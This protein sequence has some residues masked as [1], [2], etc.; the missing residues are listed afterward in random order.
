MPRRIPLLF[1]F[2]AVV[3]T[4]SASAQTNLDSFSLGKTQIRIPTPDGFAPV[5]SQ[6]PRVFGRF[7]ATESADN[8]V[9]EVHVE[10]RLL[11]DLIRN[12]DV[13]LIFY[14]KVSA[15]REAVVLD[16][17][18]FSTL[19]KQ[20]ESQIGGFFDPR[21]PQLAAATQSIRKG[22]SQHNREE[23]SFDLKA[24]KDLGS[25]ERQ[26]NVF[27]HIVLLNVE[28]RRGTIPLLAT[29]SIM[30]L[31]GRLVFVSTYRRLTE[32]MDAESLRDFAKKW[33][34]EILAANEPA[35]AVVR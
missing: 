35:T 20:L 31:N 7:T 9:L 25:F 28:T 34:A 32:V 4:A 15:P 16:Q 24:T 3:L 21:N 23:S 18:Q 11:T 5:S 1:A 6:F 26:P 27:S 22:M 2:V 8:V 17:Q 10:D 13:D 29:S 12:E 33:T 19:I 30:L 14:T